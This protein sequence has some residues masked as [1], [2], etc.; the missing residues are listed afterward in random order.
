MK[1]KLLVSASIIAGV[2]AAGA[3]SVVIDG[4]PRDT[5]FTIHS[6]AVKIKKQYPEVKP[7]YNPVAEGTLQEREN[8]IY[9]TPRSGRDLHVDVYRPA[10]VEKPLPAVLMIHGGGWNSGDRTIQRPL[11][12]AL[13][14]RGFVTIP[15][16]YRL[17]PEALY[18]AGLIDVKRAIE[19][20]RL[21][22]DS[23]GVNP[24]CIAVSGCSAGGQLAALAGVTNG[25]LR[26][27]GGDRRLAENSRVG[28]VINIDGIVTFISE[29]NIKDVADRVA[30]KGTWPVNAQWLGGLPEMTP[31]HWREAS[32]LEWITPESAP[33][34]F[35]NSQL[36]RYHDGRDSLVARYDSIGIPTRVVENDSQFH[37]FWFFDRWFEPTVDAAASFLKEIF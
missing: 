14:S 15:V 17:I 33:V 1:I 6:T 35:I 21:N 11:A 3:Q 2:L 22:A 18:P 9:S 23:L 26:H 8:L 12:K 16:E 19:W 32:A 13:A 4:I 10:G 5:S 7:V 29:Y 20:V 37:A 28:A 36:P 25:S 27:A 31:D 24:D 34:C 30:K